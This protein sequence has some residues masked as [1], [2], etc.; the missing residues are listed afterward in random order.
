MASFKE[1]DL[2]ANG[3]HGDERDIEL[4]NVAHSEKLV[5][6][7][8]RKDGTRLVLLF[9]LFLALLSGILFGIALEKGRGK[10]P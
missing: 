1:C 10:L 4:N 5:D 7:K 6:E 9:K 2:V 8:A 3:N